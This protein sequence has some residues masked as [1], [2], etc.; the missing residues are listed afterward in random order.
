MEGLTLRLGLFFILFTLISGENVRAIVYFPADTVIKYQVTFG[1]SYHNYLPGK[2]LRIEVAFKNNS[3]DELKVSQELVVLDSANNK[4]WKTIINLEL[5]SKGSTSIPLLIPAPKFPG[6]YRLTT[7]DSSGKYGEENPLFEVNVV[8]PKKSP[9]L[10]KI[11]VHTP[12]SEVD[13]GAFLKTWGIK[14]P[15]VS[16]GQVLLCGKKT[17]TLF[18]EG[19]QEITQL[20]SR[21]LRREMSVIFLDF[22]PSGPIDANPEKMLLPFGVS[23]S[24]IKGAAAEKSFILKSDIKELT[25]DFSNRTMRNW[26]GFD[27]VSVPGTDIRFEGKG[28]KIIACATSGENNL[29]Y[30]VVEIIPR[31]GKG[32]LYLSQ[33]ITDG[34]VMDVERSGRYNPKA[35][36][37]DPM[38]VQFLLNLISATVGDNLLK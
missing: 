27:G 19:D 14:A 17:W 15:M 2:L 30:P 21:A 11:L 35:P 1:E 31:D 3:A 10:T 9:R 32:K 12:D 7:G 16:W 13:L 24:F 33:I 5:Q 38:A 6:T 26:N 4:T 37:Y 29:R 18:M 22:G 25:Y 28:V 8:V 34:R 36:A 20:I 23:V